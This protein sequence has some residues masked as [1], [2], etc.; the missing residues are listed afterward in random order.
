[1]NRTVSADAVRILFYPVASTQELYSVTPNSCNENEA[2]VTAA[3][4][5]NLNECL[6]YLDTNNEPIFLSFSVE[7]NSLS[8]SVYENDC[9]SKTDINLKFLEYSSSGI[10]SILLKENVCGLPA[11]LHGDS[12]L[13]LYQAQTRAKWQLESCNPIP[14]ATQRSSY[15]AVLAPVVS[16]LIQK[17]KEVKS[18][19]SYKSTYYLHE[20]TGSDTCSD[21][22]SPLWAKECIP[23]DICLPFKDGTS[24]KITAR[25]SG[26]QIGMYLFGGCNS[27]M[28]VATADF[29]TSAGVIASEGQCAST[30]LL[31]G[32]PQ[33]PYD[34]AASLKYSF[35]DC[36]VASP[37]V[38]RFGF[39][40]PTSVNNL[41]TAA[42]VV[43]VARLYTISLV[44]VISLFGILL[45]SICWARK[46]TVRRSG[47]NVVSQY[48]DSIELTSAPKFQESFP[49]QSSFYQ[50]QL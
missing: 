7:Q 36:P 8:V 10:G 9:A 22:E 44:G 11:T 37:I 5:F 35:A 43:S 28:Q 6:P 24:M 17:S 14:S 16:E 49:T 25:E 18:M 46:R 50:Q 21:I 45:L 30:V 38:S 42:H 15:P 34:G 27:F 19:E 33:Y 12:I 26:L 2:P 29:G 48:H 23:N 47:Y 41:L 4:C 13:P 1:M 32:A 39:Q 40:I 3:A 31:N 20:Y